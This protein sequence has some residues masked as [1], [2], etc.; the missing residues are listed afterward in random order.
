MKQ[1]FFD[2]KIDTNGQK[3]YDFTDQTI[4]WIKNKDF[5]NGILNLNIQQKEFYFHKL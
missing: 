3:L 1:E 4:E 2:F 5:N